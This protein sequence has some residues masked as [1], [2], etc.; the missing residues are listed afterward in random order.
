MLT[1]YW[2]CPPGRR[3]GVAPV[4]DG[5]GVGVEERIRPEAGGQDVG[6]GLGDLVELGAEVEVLADQPVDGGIEGQAVRGSRRRP[7]LGEFQRPVERGFG[8]PGGGARAGRCR[9]GPGRRRPPG[10]GDVG[11]DSRPGPPR[12]VHHDPG[13]VARGLAESAAPGP[14]RGAEGRRPPPRV[15]R[16]GRVRGEDLGSCPGGRHDPRESEDQATQLR[17]SSHHVTPSPSFVQCGVSI[18]VGPAGRTV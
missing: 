6:L 9:S 17:A 5:R 4:G 3:V 16:L 13:G 12:A 2:V 15:P 14:G 1:S 8:D 18:S 11:G 10:S 7:A